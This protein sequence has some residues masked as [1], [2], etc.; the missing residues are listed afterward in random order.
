MKKEKKDI[1]TEKPQKK[2]RKPVYDIQ[3]F[4]ITIPEETLNE[5]LLE[6]SKPKTE[7]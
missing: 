5:I 3:G 4:A 1:K 7:K 2:K 6:M